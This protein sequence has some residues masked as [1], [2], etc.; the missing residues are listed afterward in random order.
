MNTNEIRTGEYR[1]VNS[2]ISKLIAL[3]RNPFYRRTLFR[4]RVAAAVEHDALLKRLGKDLRTVV[5]IG[6]NRGQFALVARFHAPEARIIAFE[7]LEEPAEVFQRM[8]R[9]DTLM[10]LHRCAVGAHASEAVMHLSKADDSSSLLPITALQTRVFPGT[11]ERGTRR[12]TVRPLTD[13]LLPRQITPPSLL[14]I[15]VQGYE[16]QVLE[17]GVAL[18]DCFDYLLVECSYAVFYKDQAL[19]GEVLS[20]LEKVGFVLIQRCNLIYDQHGVPLQADFFFQRK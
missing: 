1:K 17:G 18:L 4:Y 14:K 13:V 3:L 12:V 15:D 9:Q 8:F 10:E 19:A 2:R 5:D 11:Q 16:L 7:P 20:Y 6:A